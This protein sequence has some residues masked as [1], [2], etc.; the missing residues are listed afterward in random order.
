[1]ILL[2]DMYLVYEISIIHFVQ[3]VN[4]IPKLIYFL[5]I[6]HMGFCDFK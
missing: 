4:K 5:F 1:M 2:S 3:K 6:M